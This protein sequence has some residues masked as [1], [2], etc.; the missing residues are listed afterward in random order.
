M[1]NV[2][3]LDLAI[4]KR[5]IKRNN[6]KH[7]DFLEDERAK[8]F[9]YI[10]FLKSEEMLGDY[11]RCREIIDYALL[12]DAESTKDIDVMIDYLYQRTEVLYNKMLHLKNSKGE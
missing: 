4:A 2:I 10:S 9:G 1:S 12:N 7:M 5:E 11:G 3:Q 6:Q 8:V